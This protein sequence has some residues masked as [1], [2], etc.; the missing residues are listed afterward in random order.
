MKVVA[1]LLAPLAAASDWQWVDIEGSKCIDEKQTGVWTRQG[2]GKNLGV[3][4]YPGGA[5]FN[6]ETCDLLDDNNPHPNNPGQSGIFESRSDNP[7]VDYNWMAVPYCTGDVHSGEIAHDFAG[8]FRNFSGSPNLKLHMQYA[9]QTFKDVDTLFITGESAGGFGAYAS[10]ITMRDFYP[11]ARG[12]LMDDSGPILDDDALPVCLQELWRNAWDL[13][14]NFPA[15][16]P[17]NN[18]EGNLGSLWSYGKERYPNDSFSLVSSQTDAVI[19]TF[20][21]YSELNCHTLLPVGYN[22]LQAGLERLAK[23]SSVYMIPGNGHTHTSHD[24]FYS[25]NVS[26]VPLFK[27]I[28]QLVDPNQPDPA[29]VE[30]TAVDIWNEIYPR[31]TAASMVV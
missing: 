17:G 2:A 20:F 27:W 11:E 10:Y 31:K 21:G 15:D 16:F 3:Y 29:S 9:T 12:V 8:G 30:P 13:N 1:L 4:L 18:D 14:K 23:E 24:E 28:E 19:S 5:C 25:R 26:G 7:L 22:K 6:R